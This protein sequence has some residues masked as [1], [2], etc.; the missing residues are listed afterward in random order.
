[1]LLLTELSE[2]LE[3]SP[4]IEIALEGHQ[5]GST[6]NWTFWRLVWLGPVVPLNLFDLQVGR[7]VEVGLEN[8]VQREVVVLLR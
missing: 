3:Q 6:R 5:Q 2:R 7:Q 4:V 1:M 8:G